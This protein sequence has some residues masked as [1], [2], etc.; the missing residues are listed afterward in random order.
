MVVDND[1][2]ASIWN[3]YFSSLIHLKLIFGILRDW[4]EANVETK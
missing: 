4:F 3:E 2:F 1:Y